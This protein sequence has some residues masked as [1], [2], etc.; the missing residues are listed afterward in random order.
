MSPRRRL[1]PVPD[2]DIP[3][4]KRPAHVER[5]VRTHLALADELADWLTLVDGDLELN[6]ARLLTALSVVGAQLVPT[7]PVPSKLTI[8]QAALNELMGRAAKTAPRKR[9]S[10]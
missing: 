6:L 10:S 9:A 5:D 3:V 7:R 2:E 1:T 4:S 8:A